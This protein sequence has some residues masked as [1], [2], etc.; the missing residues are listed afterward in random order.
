[1]R[2]SIYQL[3]VLF[4]TLSNCFSFSPCCWATVLCW[5]SGWFQA[6]QFLRFSVVRAKPQAVS[7]LSSKELSWVLKKLSLMDA[8]VF[9]SPCGG[10]PLNKMCKGLPLIRAL[11]LS[12]RSCPHRA[13]NCLASIKVDGL[14][15]LSGPHY[16]RTPSQLRSS[17]SVSM[18]S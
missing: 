12:F 14:N 18:N 11:A 13:S 8:R 3:K 6:K 17:L 5:H 16:L 9:L 2:C 10:T 7:T 4:R 15:L 1:M